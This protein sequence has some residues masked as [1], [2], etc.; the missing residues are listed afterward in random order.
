MEPIRLLFKLGQP[1]ILTRNGWLL[2]LRLFLFFRFG[3][4]RQ[5]ARGAHTDGN[6]ASANAHCTADPA[7]RA[8]ADT[9]ATEAADGNVN[10]HRRTHVGTP[11]QK[12]W[13]KEASS[14]DEVSRCSY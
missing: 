9:H 3:G 2:K 5:L 12:K 8:D 10:A 14:P 11:H 1:S 6:T 13:G 4:W 7:V